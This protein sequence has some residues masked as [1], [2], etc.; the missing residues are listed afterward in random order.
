MTKAIH[1]IIHGRVQGVGFRAWF[2]SNAKK[3]ELDGWVRNRTDGTVEAV[4]CGDI[5]HMEQ[6]IKATHKGSLAS[7]VTQLEQSDIHELPAR[8]FVKR[9]TV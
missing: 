1:L 3:H 4:I 7:K 8:G 6:M 2:A 5:V 9:D